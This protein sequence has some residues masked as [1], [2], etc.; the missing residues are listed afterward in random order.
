M[1]SG[2]KPLSF[3][4]RDSRSLMGITLEMMTSRIWGRNAGIS[5]KLCYVL[6]IYIANI[7]TKFQGYISSGFS[8]CSD[9]SFGDGRSRGWDG[10]SGNRVREV[11]FCTR[12]FFI[13]GRDLDF[14]ERKCTIIRKSVR[15]CEL[16]NSCFLHET[17]DTR[18]R[19]G[20]E[21]DKMS[22]IFVS[23][24]RFALAAP[25]IAHGDGL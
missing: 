2:W 14:L 3:F 10:A 24:D 16:L 6:H 13:R 11:T 22:Y 9:K 7:Y 18:T 20:L 12:D 17:S 1:D 25:I 15:I 23:L 4:F 8:G 19:F 5:T 21:E